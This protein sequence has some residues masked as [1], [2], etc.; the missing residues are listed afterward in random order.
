MNASSYSALNSLWLYRDVHRGKTVLSKSLSTVAA[1]GVQISII[2]S[3]Y[4]FP[5]T[6]LSVDFSLPLD[7]LLILFHLQP[8]PLCFSFAFSLYPSCQSS[9]ARTY[10]HFW[11]IC[12]STFLIHSPLPKLSIFLPSEKRTCCPVHLSP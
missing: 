1:R 8:Q 3:H 6:R 7:F 5:M 12:T 2:P 9:P 10:P 11:T 4:S